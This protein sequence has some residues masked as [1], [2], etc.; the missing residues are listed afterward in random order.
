MMKRREERSK[1]IQK[2]LDDEENKSQKWK[3]QVTATIRELERQ[4]A[5]SR[6]SDYIDIGFR[7]QKALSTLS[8]SPISS[9]FIHHRVCIIN[10]ILKAADN[11]VKLRYGFIDVDYEGGPFSGDAF[12]VVKLLSETAGVSHKLFHVFTPTDRHF[13][14]SYGNVCEVDC[15]GCFAQSHDFIV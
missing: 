13:L 5:M 3:A 6:S 1:R 8:L 11:I 15:V 2:I 12:P 14:R 10:A 4:L 7:Q 9:P